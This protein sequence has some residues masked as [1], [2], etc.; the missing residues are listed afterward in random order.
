MFFIKIDD[1]MFPN[2]AFNS[3]VI[4]DTGVQICWGDSNHS[5]IE[6]KYPREVFEALTRSFARVELL[7]RIHYSSSDTD[8]DKVYDSEDNAI[9]DVIQTATYAEYDVE[10]KK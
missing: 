4:K 10:Q 3:M 6:T 7:S 8:K 5:F 2:T 1:V 9:F